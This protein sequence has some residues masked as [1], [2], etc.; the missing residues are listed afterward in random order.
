M[1]VRTV[2]V[3]VTPRQRL[4]VTCVDNGYATTIGV[5]VPHAPLPFRGCVCLALD[6]AQRRNAVLDEF[7]SRCDPTSIY[8]GMFVLC[9]WMAQLRR[10]SS[11]EV[12]SALLRV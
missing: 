11:G 12:R 7:E 4:C 5:R 9:P 3:V 10:A 1:F 6:P 2:W 8:R